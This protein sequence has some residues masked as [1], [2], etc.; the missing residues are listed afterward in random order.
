MAATTGQTGKCYSY[1]GLKFY[2][3][4]GFICLHDEQTGEFF[5]LTRKEFLQ[6]AQAISEEARRLRHMAAENPA[7]AAWLSADRAELQVAIENMVA[8]TKEAKE[9]GDRDD[10]TVD[11]WFRRHRP[12]KKSKISL[13]SGANFTSAL[14]GSLPLGKDTGRYVTPDFSVGESPKKLILPGEF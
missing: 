5:V 9:Q 12:G 11:A 13:A 3:Q 2:A 8:V 4:N 1:R 14:P 10:P 7:K 6:R